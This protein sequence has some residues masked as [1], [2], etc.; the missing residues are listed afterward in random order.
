MR[1]G[2]VVGSTRRLFRVGWLVGFLVG[3]AVGGSEVGDWL[4]AAAAKRVERPFSAF[5]PLPNNSKNPINRQKTY[6]PIPARPFL[7]SACLAEE[8]E[9]G[10]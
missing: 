1:E 6:R 4:G 10:R 8:S 7:A 5:G 2:L 3:V 9:M